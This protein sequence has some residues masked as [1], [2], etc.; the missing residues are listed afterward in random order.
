MGIDWIRRACAVPLAKVGYRIRFNDGHSEKDGTIVG[1]KDGYLRV[2]FDGERGIYSLH[3]IWNV[4]Y[5][6]PPAMGG[7]P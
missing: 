6:G 7:K 5:L 3:P 4:G 2:R 1:A